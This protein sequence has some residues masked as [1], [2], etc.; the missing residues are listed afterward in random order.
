MS[1]AVVEIQRDDRN[2]LALDVLPDVQ[3]GPVQERVNADVRAGRKI[4][5][6][7]IPEFRRLIRRV[8]LHVGVARREIA[9]LG[10]RGVFV[11]PHADDDAGVAVVLDDLLQAVLLEHAA[12]FDARR[13]AVRIRV[14]RLEHRLVHADDELQVPLADQAVAVLDHRRNLVGRVDVDERKRHVAEKCLPREPQQGR[15]VLADA[16]KH[17]HVVELGEGLAHDENRFALE[18]VQVIVLHVSG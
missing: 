18:S 17:R 15:R 10:A 5:L 3:L 2:L 16:P 1:R 6:E 12:A 8:P 4:G 7:L 14:A 11:A 9:L 13:A